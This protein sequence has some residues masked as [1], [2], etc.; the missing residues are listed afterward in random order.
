ME[1]HAYLI[2]QYTMLKRH[3]AYTVRKIWLHTALQVSMIL[4]PEGQAPE[5][6]LGGSFCQ[7]DINFHREKALAGTWSNVGLCH[8][9]F[10]LWLAA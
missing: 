6:S 4:H 3:S 10:R 1:C 7:R 2:G 8:S 9:T 5:W